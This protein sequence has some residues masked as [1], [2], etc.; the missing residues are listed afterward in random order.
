M[1]RILI[2]GISGFVGRHF[3]KFLSEQSEEC[4]VCG[5][6]IR[7]PSYDVEVYRKKLGL[8]IEAV[9]LLNIAA[10][11]EILEAFRPNYILHLASFSSVAYSWKHP[12]DS[13]VNN[14]NIFLNLVTAVG[15]TCPDCR[16]LSIGS[17]EEYGNVTEADIPLRE[18]MPTAPV[19]PYAVARVSQEMLSKLYVQHYGM[20]IIM[21][22]SFNHI[23]PWQDE[24]FVIPS[25]IMRSLELKNKG[26]TEGTIETGDVSVIRDFVDVRD[27]VRAYWLLL[28]NGVKGELYNV[29][30]GNGHRLSELI[31]M[32]GN[33][34]GIHIQAKPNPEYIRPGDNQIIIG[35]KSKL[36]SLLSWKPQYKL[37]DTLRDMITDYIGSIE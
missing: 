13:F 23:G 1:D 16:I 34:M 36:A 35:D 17:S 8:K 7:I 26:L 33:I 28:K 37:Q 15:E 4:K 14:T 18:D 9:D 20:D 2:T 5:I 30:S 6:D 29:C 3:L 12:A 21:T 19:S 32:I 25:F 10:V 27:V 11:R 31:D 22:R 24:R